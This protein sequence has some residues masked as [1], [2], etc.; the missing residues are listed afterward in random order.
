MVF[1]YAR[2][3]TNEKKQDIDRQ[4]R[5][6]R[7]LGVDNPDNIYWEYESGA[8]VDRVQL[9]RLLATVKQGDT[10]AVTE[11]SRLTRSMKHLCE[12][13]QIVQERHLQLIIG[14]F[15][16]DCRKDE[17]DAMTQGMIMMWGVFAQMERRITQERVRSGVANAKAKGKRLG[18]P[19][20]S[21]ERLPAK[22][23]QYYPLYKEEQIT[24]SDFAKM[25]GCTRKTLYGYIHIYEGNK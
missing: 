4:K 23:V 6:L 1:G 20:L 16:A 8:N 25:V 10:I 22:F 21:E 15:N 12:L 18:R 14:G 5:E 19:A 24:L 9:N 11:V 2:C 13:L 7:D 3:S 17:L